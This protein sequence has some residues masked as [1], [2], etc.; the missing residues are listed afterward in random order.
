MGDI[1]YWIW[2]YIGFFPHLFRR[3]FHLSRLMSRC[4]SAVEI[5][6]I[7]WI[8]GRAILL[9]WESESGHLDTEQHA[10]GGLTRL[11]SSFLFLPSC[12]FHFWHSVSA[13][14]PLCHTRFCPTEP[15]SGILF[16]WSLTC[17][18]PLSITGEANKWKGQNIYNK[19]NETSERHVRKGADYQY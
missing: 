16:D 12:C 13:Q 14:I 17:N 15:L 5:S 7:D 4:C 18:V 2:Y 1:V 19:V 10:G 6:M 11:C 3:L 8:A 9:L